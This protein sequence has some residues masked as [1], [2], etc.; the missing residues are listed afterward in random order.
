MNLAILLILSFF[1]VIGTKDIDLLSGSAII[2]P[3]FPIPLNYVLIILMLVFPL[4]V[5]QFY[6]KSKIKNIDTNGNPS[7]QDADNKVRFFVVCILIIEFLFYYKICKFHSSILN[8][9]S[10][11][12]ILFTYY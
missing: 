8:L 3:D 2:Y 4:V 6:D 10:I 11:I 12:S 9:C 1:I 5:L 7:K